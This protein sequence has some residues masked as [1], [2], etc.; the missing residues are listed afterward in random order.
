M[1]GQALSTGKLVIK[2]NKVDMTIDFGVPSELKITITDWS[3]PDSDIMG[4]IQK[5]VQLAED[6]GYVVNKAITSL[7]MIN[8]MRN[9]RNADRS[10]WS[11]K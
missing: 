8:N 6:G 10:S 3:K 5:M 2:E 7:K 1:K 9:N 4:D 11:C